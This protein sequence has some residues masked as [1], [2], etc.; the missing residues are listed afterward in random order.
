MTLKDEFFGSNKEDIYKQLALDLNGRFAHGNFYN[1]TKVDVP[2]KSWTIHKRQNRK[3]KIAYI[4]ILPAN[5]KIMFLL[6]G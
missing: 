5:I 6:N 3:T 2:F 4:S 1:P